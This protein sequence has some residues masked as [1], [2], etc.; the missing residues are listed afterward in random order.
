MPDARQAMESMV[1][2]RDDVCWSTLFW[3]VLLTVTLF[4]IWFLYCLKLDLSPDEAYYWDWSRHLSWGYYSKPPM[5][6]WLIW[7]FSSMLGH[8]SFAVRLPAALLGSVT[9][10]CLYFLG[11]WMFNVR[12]GFWAAMGFLATLGSALA[13]M[14]M[15]IDAPLLCFWSLSMAATWK[16]WRSS[17]EDH[18][19][20]TSWWL[21]AGFVTGLGILSKQTMAGFTI[22]MILFLLLS[23]EGRRLLTS[24]FPWIWL[25]TQALV[26]FPVLVW[27]YHH[28][29]ITFQHTAHHF[30]PA[31]AG[32]PDFQTFFE[33]MGSQLGIV[34]PIIFV[35]IIVFSLCLLWQLVC[36]MLQRK[37]LHLQAHEHVRAYLLVFGILPLLAVFILALRQRIN[38]NWPAPFYLSSAI[39]VSSWAMGGLDCRSAVDRLRKFFVPGIGLGLALVA[40]FYL[41]PVALNTFDL[42]GSRLDPTV[43]LR[44]WHELGLEAGRLLE[45]FPSP[46]KAFVVARRRQTASELAF[47]MP[48]QPEVYRWNGRKRHITSQY[49][50]WPGPLDRKGQDALMVFEDA[51]ELPEDLVSCFEQVK[52]MKKIVISLGH[53]RERIFYAYQGMHM[54]HWAD[55]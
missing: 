33:L 34:T 25:I 36:G 8:S 5:V 32:F 50:L 23:M 27:N 20:S 12:I 22:G 15:T 6:A 49:E 30:K 13:S 41:L 14:I 52:Y 44:G 24:R 2:E 28:G 35:L 39:L 17:L 9:I 29:W 54:R 16:A 55:R 3:L 38:A 40:A 42:A 18:G 11:K 46:G 53:G 4:R 31:S 48:G 1:N 19:R 10:V 43:R 37:S 26:I 47:Y 21:L 7:F 45:Q 51:S